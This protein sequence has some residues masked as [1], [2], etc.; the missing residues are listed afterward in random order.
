MELP[1]PFIGW[2]FALLS[3]AALAAGLL[4][5]LIL[6]LRGG[7]QERNF[8][9]YSFWNDALL[10][11]IWIL[12]LAA[13]IGVIR[14]QP[15][16]RYLMELFCWCL[17]VLVVLS[18]MTRLYAL[19][20][21]QADEPVNWL[22]SIAGVTLVLIPLLALCAGTIITLRGDAARLAFSGG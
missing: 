2:F 9:S 13:G 4:L 16:S 7:Q 14:L 1:L 6:T 8:L 21:R 22:G 10:G 18:A 5:I 15:W 12:G 20:Q 19:K 17:I 11:G 3:V